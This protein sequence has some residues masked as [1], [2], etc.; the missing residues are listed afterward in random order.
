MDVRRLAEVASDQLTVGRVFGE[1][2][3]QGSLTIIPVARLMGAAGGGQGISPGE[4]TDQAAQQ[5]E[6][7][8]WG[9]VARPA[10]VYVVDGERVRWRPALDGDRALT[11]AAVVLVLLGVIRGIAR[12]RTRP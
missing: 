6:G 8:G 11:T 2:I 9:V 5:G 3:R 1:P 10:G 12:R 7:G 4:G